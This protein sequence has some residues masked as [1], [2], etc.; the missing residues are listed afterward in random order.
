MKYKTLSNG[1]Q[2]PSIG[3]GTYP[4]Y[5]KQLTDVLVMAYEEGYRLIDTADNYYNEKDLGESLYY[6]YN[7]LGAKREDFFLVSKV[8]DELYPIGDY[9][10]GSNRG[11][12]FWKSSRIMQ[13]PN[14]VREILEEKIDNTL[15]FLKTDYLDLWLMH[16]PYPDFFLEIWHEMEKIYAA[17]KVKAIGVCN[18]RVRHLKALRDQGLS[19]PMVNQFE[20]SPLNTKEE[21]IDYCINHGIEV[22]TYSPLMSLRFKDVPQYSALLTALS[23]KYY[24]NPAQIILRF[25]IQRGLI[26]IPK[27]IHRNRLAANIDLFDFELTDDEM[28]ALMNCNQNRQTLPE[29]KQCPGL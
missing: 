4:L 12:Y 16:W 26:P 29:S 11:V 22:M 21:I 27:S 6:I 25:D 23:E 7:Q 20:S 13:S 24:K 2:M 3:L 28:L 9:R 1:I 8:S 19:I 18:C 5:A 10:A 15:R 14:A 17:G